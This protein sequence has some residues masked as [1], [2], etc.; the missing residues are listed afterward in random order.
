MHP[1]GK[2]SR[3]NDA[4][5]DALPSA[6]AMA[7]LGLLAIAPMTAYGMAEQTHRAFGYVWSASRSLL[8]SQPKK[9]ADAGLAE[10]LPPTDGSRASKR[11][12]AS[13]PGRQALRHWLSTDVEPTRVS[14]EIGLRLILADQSDRA[15]LQRQLQIR[16][17]QLRDAIRDG[18]SF[19]DGYLEG[20]GPFPQRMHIVAA[21]LSFIEYQV[22]GELRGLEAVEE[23]VSAWTDTA[24]AAP[25]RDLAEMRKIR[26]RLVTMLDQPDESGREPNRRR[27]IRS[28]ELPLRR[29]SDPARSHPRCAPASFRSRSR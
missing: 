5:A 25:K 11:W 23:Q 8:L 3:E 29:P 9:L 13:E 18:I 1:V 10:S 22:V 14:S 26:A 6:N 20:D 15:T 7:V 19:A 16:R 24:T 4:P 21:M 12:G 2:A 28:A 17:T 27:R